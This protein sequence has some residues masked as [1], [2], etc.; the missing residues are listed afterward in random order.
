[1][2]TKITLI[3]LLLSGAV[4]TFS[5]CKKSSSSAGP[6]LTPKQVSSQI[7]LNITETLEDGFGGFSLSSGFNSAESLGLIPKGRLRLNSTNDPLCG[8][9]IDTTLNY[10]TNAS[11]TSASVKG[12]LKFAFT[13]TNGEISGYNVTDNLAII[14][15]TS[16]FSV[17]YKF[18]EDLTLAAVNPSSETTN[19]TLNGSLSLGGTFTYTSGAKGS[20]SQNFSYT[21]NSV[22][23]DYTGQ[24]ISG[25]AT[26][27]TSGT[28]SGGV[29]NYSGTITFLGGGKANITING[30]TYNVDLATGTVS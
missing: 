11:G 23:A 29:W 26:F 5:G 16:S 8:T 6:A 10:S 4:I 9:I 3:V 22:T 17:N 18:I 27:S 14:E 7:A 19:V 2:K 28:G 21:F 25:S 24:L 12:S 20:G 13:C 30:S 1:M 15:S